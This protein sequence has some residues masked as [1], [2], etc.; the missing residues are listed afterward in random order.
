MLEIDFFLEKWITEVPPYAS[1]FVQLSLLN[2]LVEVI[3]HTNTTLNA[4]TGKIRNYQLL[5]C[6]GYL[7]IFMGSYLV[8]KLSE[9]PVLAIAVT[10]IV[11][12]I[13]IFPRLYITRHTLGITVGY[14]F[15]HVILRLLVMSLLSAAVCLLFMHYV[16]DGWVR[17][18]SV[19]AC[20]HCL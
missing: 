15:K 18:L 11:N 17:F 8:L 12:I 13:L 9:N 3:L 5:L 1:I 14:F 19:C 6:T 7:L 2:N 10:N 16:E 20:R 4:A